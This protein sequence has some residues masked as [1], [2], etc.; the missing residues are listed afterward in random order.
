MHLL[1]P[2]PW[3]PARRKGHRRNRNS[4]IRAKCFAPHRG[5][6]ARGS[7]RDAPA[8]GIIP[9][10]PTPARCK[11]SPP[12]SDRTRPRP[13]PPGATG[14]KSNNGAEQYS[15]AGESRDPEAGPLAAVQI[16]VKREGPH[17]NAEQRLGRLT[18]S[19]RN[20]ANPSR[21]DDGEGEQQRQGQG[22]RPQPSVESFH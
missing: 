15:G 17:S 13:P 6:K 11:S 22:P 21:R 12:G 3:C 1:W 4:N 2:M 20:V 10:R 5:E 14:K 18:L 19:E 9:M 7:K 8:R 16:P